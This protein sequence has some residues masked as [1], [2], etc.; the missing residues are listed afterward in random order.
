[1]EPVLSGLEKEL[2][3]IMARYPDKRSGLIPVLWLVQ[4]KLGW[5]PDEVFPELAEAAGVAATEVEEV[6][7]FYTMFNRKETGHYILQVCKTLPC[8]LCGGLGLSKYLQ[9]TL[10]VG[11]NEPTADGVFT[12]LEVEC[13]GACSEAP[14]MLVNEKMET[15]LT[16]EKVD[17]IL[18]RC[19]AEA[20]QSKADSAEEQAS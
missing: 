20:P 7:S 11:L 19:R 16:R 17:R 3:E 13:L 2:E 14:L 15:R 18:E 6:V 5:V 1:M 4:R 10:K 12:I 9:E 8:A